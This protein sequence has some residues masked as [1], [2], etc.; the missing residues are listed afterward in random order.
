MKENDKA[1]ALFIN[2]F[3][4]V[5]FDQA[6][7]F[8]LVLD[9]SLIP[10]ETAAEWIVAA[11]QMAETSTSAGGYLA[12]DIQEDPILADVIDKVLAED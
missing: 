11:A 12:K 10:A 9:T 5:S 4:D 3:Y 7:Q 8:H 2:G 6:E 1:R